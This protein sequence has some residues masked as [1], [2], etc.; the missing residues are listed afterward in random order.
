MS[1]SYMPQKDSDLL[2]WLQNLQ[3]KIATHATTLGLTTAQVTEVQT[4]CTQMIDAINLVTQKR[5]EYK[6]AVKAR[7]IALETEVGA[8]RLMVAHI[9]T[10]STY[11]D[12][13]GTDLD[14][15]STKLGFDPNSYKAS[16]SAEI[17]GG[18]V[19][20]KFVKRGAEGINLY[21]RLKGTPDWR[22]LARATKSPFDDH[23]ALA[24]AN[25]PEHWEY[26]AFG[27][28]DDAEIGQTSDIVEVIFGG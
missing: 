2:V 9:K 21:H 23:I 28:I 15:V 7:D 20:V 27:V 18:V 3:T 16:I 26:R 6:S 14:V 10:L 4:H 22:F 17:A 8:I 24:V 5:D 25:Q 11:T 12:V 13:I 19:R 1:K